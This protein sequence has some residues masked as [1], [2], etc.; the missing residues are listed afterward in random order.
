MSGFGLSPFGLTAFG[1]ATAEA[2]FSFSVERGTITVDASASIATEGSS[3][4]YAWDYGDGGSGS[5]EV[6]SH[7]YLEFGT[8]TV[9]LV[10]TDDL[11]GED[12]T[13]DS[14]EVP[15]WRRTSMIAAT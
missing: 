10:L 9:T 3:P 2:A 7:S 14:V 6:A 13:S 1:Q 11:G 5:G 15:A 8:Y 12:E 4:T